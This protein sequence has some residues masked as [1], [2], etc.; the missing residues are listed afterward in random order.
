MEHECQCADVSQLAYSQ[1][2][3]FGHAS[4]M[5]LCFM[6]TEIF[7]MSLL[8]DAIDFTISS[9]LIARGSVLS[10]LDDHFDHVA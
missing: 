2:N 4:S 3:T 1:C 7:K 9:N 10:N 6:N 5:N 8:Q